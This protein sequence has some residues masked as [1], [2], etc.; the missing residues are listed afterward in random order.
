MNVY[1]FDNT[2]YDGESTFD[3][4]LFCLRKR[5]KLIKFLYKF[6][7]NIVKYK[8]CLINREKMTKL[9]EENISDILAV[10]P[11]YTELTE[12]FWKKSINKIKKFYLEQKKDDDVIISASFDYLLKPVCRR[13]GVNNL[14]CSE[15]DL[16][17]GKVTKLCFRE[18][19]PGCFKEMFPDAE[20]DNF[21]TDSKNDLPFMLMAQNS[22]FVKGEKIIPADKEKLK[23]KGE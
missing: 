20:I 10:C 6:C 15:A 12:E 1:D 3:F 16:E 14:I 22:F 7:S 21:Y 8:L 13:L 2:I 11:D 4:F 18:N 19:K 17:T 5:P 23:A 9:V